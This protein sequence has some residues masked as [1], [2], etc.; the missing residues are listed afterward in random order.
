MSRTVGKP[1]VEEL[2]AGTELELLSLTP[3]VIAPSPADDSTTD[4]AEDD[5]DIAIAIDSASCTISGVD[6]VAEE[7]VIEEIGSECDDVGDM[8]FDTSDM[9]DT[10]LTPLRWI[11]VPTRYSVVPLPSLLL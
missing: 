1:G 10:D 7:V 8:G 3:A 5:V 6:V 2:F 11:N 4:E 9:S